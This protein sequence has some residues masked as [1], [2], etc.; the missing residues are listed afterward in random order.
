M[1]TNIKNHGKEMSHQDFIGKIFT[2]IY[3]SENRATVKFISDSGE[4]FTIGGVGSLPNAYIENVTGDI[5]KLIGT[6]ILNTSIFVYQSP[7]EFGL[8]SR[9][10]T[11]GF[12]TATGVV[13][14]Q[15]TGVVEAMSSPLVSILSEDS[16]DAPLHATIPVRPQSL[17]NNT[18]KEGKI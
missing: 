17:M 14:I 7:I 16:E 3:F 11:Y 6:R 18:D 10:I 15:W 12:T 13:G 5:R 2:N 4:R 9:V 1:D 8:F